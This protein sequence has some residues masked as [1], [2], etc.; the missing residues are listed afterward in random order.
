MNKRSLLIALALLVVGGL[1]AIL[2]QWYI[3]RNPYQGPITE[4]DL[5][6][7]A[8]RAGT[9]R[10]Q[11]PPAIPV[12]PIPLSH[13]VRLAIGWLGLADDAQNRVLGDLLA[14]DLSKA[15]GLELVERES[16]N[17]VLHEM[18]LNLSGLVRAK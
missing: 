4:Q 14:V 1:A 5:A 3:E 6:Q 17:R 8:G 9:A 12:P 18:E 15:E 16:L 7:A 13:V 2:I 10:D 11:I